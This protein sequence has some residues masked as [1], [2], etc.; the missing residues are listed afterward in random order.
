[1]IRSFLIMVRQIEPWIDAM[2]CLYSNSRFLHSC[3]L[4]NSHNS[5]DLNWHFG[6]LPLPFHSW[7]R[8]YYPGS[9]CYSSCSFKIYSLSLLVQSFCW[10]DLSRLS[11]VI[12]ALSFDSIVSSLRHHLHYSLIPSSFLWSLSRLCHWGFRQLSQVDQSCLVRYSKD[13]RRLHSVK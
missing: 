4:V 6:H 8:L 12:W 10:T 13:L 1:M 2:S 5:I 11:M 3:L 9:T 7:Q